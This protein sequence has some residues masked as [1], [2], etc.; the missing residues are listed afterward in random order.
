MK[1]KLFLIALGLTIVLSPPGWATNADIFDD[2]FLIWPRFGCTL[3]DADQQVAFVVNPSNNVKKGDSFS[4][5]MP[6]GNVNMGTWDRLLGSD[7]CP[8]LNSMEVSVGLIHVANPMPI[9]NSDK[10]YLGFKGSLT[11]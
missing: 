5:V 1:I 9:F 11:R 3:A 8:A 10:V 2:A 4:I 7:E 6:T